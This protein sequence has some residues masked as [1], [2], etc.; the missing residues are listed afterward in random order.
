MMSNKELVMEAVRQLPEDA[1]I[2]EIIEEEMR[3]AEPGSEEASILAALDRAEKGSDSGR[4]I[5]QE[6]VVRDLRRGSDEGESMSIELT[7]QQQHAL[8]T[9]RESLPRLIDP[10]T[11][12][13]YVL[14]PAEDYESVRRYWKTR[15]DSARFGPLACATRRAGTYEM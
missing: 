8:D 5:S 7:E 14:V 13:A 12:A 4:V 9:G 10:R 6:E 2:D 11:N 15:S 1:T 3:I